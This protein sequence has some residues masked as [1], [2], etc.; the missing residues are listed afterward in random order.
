M[1]FVNYRFADEWIAALRYEHLQGRNAGPELDD[2][3][4]EYAFA[5]S[6]RDRF[7]VA[8]TRE[9]EYK[10][11]LSLIRL[12]YSHDQTEEGDEDSV[13]LQFGFNYG[14]EDEVR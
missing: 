2:G 12:Q 10:D 5:P 1:A 11:T 4:I 9:F 3:I 7:S 6:E 14:R 13:F 8:L